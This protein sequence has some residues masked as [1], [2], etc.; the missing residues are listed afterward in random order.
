MPLVSA[1][2]LLVHDI[3]LQVINEYIFSPVTI[4]LLSNR[5]L[6]KTVLFGG[7]DWSMGRTEAIIALVDE[8]VVAA[9]IV[10]ILVV[11]GK[12]FGLV[13]AG[14]ALVL[15]GI[16]VGVLVLVGV[17]TARAQLR[18]PVLGAEAMIGKKG[19]VVEPLDPE[20]LVV[21]D[22]EYWRAVSYNKKRI[23]KNEIVIVV[24]IKGLLLQ[25]ERV[26]K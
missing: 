1:Q 23:D 19:R 10:I 20:G 13:S 15:G 24:G 4:I 3:P 22:G 2:L 9:A 26:G 5:V 6:K 14:I 21:I 17:V 11:L 7:I 12:A 25:V 8:L 18:K 16:A